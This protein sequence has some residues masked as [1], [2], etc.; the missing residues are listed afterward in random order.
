MLAIVLE[1]HLCVTCYIYVDS[2]IVACKA[3]WH[4]IRYILIQYL[5]QIVPSIVST[6]FTVLLHDVSSSNKEDL[7]KLGVVDLSKGKALI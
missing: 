3:T 1:A 4:H 6:C 5:E 2:I 7:C